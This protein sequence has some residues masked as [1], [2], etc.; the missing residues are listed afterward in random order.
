MNPKLKT[1]LLLIVILLFCAGCG[2]KDVTPDSAVQNS[3]AAVTSMENSEKSLRVEDLIS[4]TIDDPDIEFSHRLIYSGSYGSKLYLLASYQFDDG[5]QPSMWMYVFDMDTR[6]TEKNAFFMEMPEQTR[7]YIF[8]MYVTNENELTFILYGSINDKP[9]SYALCRTDLTGTFLDGDASVTEDIGY[10]ADLEETNGRLFSIPDS[11]P[12]VAEWDVDNNTA[13]ISRLDTENSD[14]TALVTLPGDMVRSLCSDGQDGF[15]Y[16]GSG[17]LKHLNLENRTSEV[18]CDLVDFGIEPY[19]GCQLL[20]NDDRKL[21]ICTVDVPSPKVYL[22]TDEEDIIDS[23]T[24]RMTRLLFSSMEYEIKLAAVWSTTSDT[25]RIKTE[26]A[27]EQDTETLRDRIMMEIASGKGPELMWVTEED[28]RILAE[29]GALMDL[30]EMIPEDVKEQLLP[31]VLKAG[32]LD[33]KLVGIAPEVSFYSM[34]VP[35]TYWSGDSWTA[36]DVMDLVE[37][38]DD[39]EWPL[40]VTYSETTAEMLFYDILGR[41]LRNSPYVDLENGISYFNGEEFIRT[42]E[43]CQEYGLPGNSTITWNEVEQM[44]YDEKT[45]ARTLYCY[46][47]LI[48][49]SDTMAKSGSTHIV[50]F[51][52]NNGS[53]SYVFGEGYLVVNANAVHI[54]EIKDYIRTLLDYENQYAVSMSPVRKDVLRDSVT[55]DFFGA[56]C[57]LK[58]YGERHIAMLTAKP[59]GSTYLEEFMEFA[60][61]CEPLPYCPEAIKNILREELAPCFNEGKSAEAAAEIIHRRVQLYFDESR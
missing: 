26:T 40:L 43:F 58:K 46:N 60:E 19:A 52:R 53:G 18:L 50:G 21:A 4:L 1:T 33:G 13:R 49:F 51:P 48:N 16:I 11:S 32:T 8:S 27:S 36:A 7:L 47:G 57:V 3:A 55:Q 29:K 10:F 37:S 35:D 2:K 22:L 24:I 28:M 12:I 59:D 30:S 42:I 5:S 25:C 39:W 56:P 23:D 38:R 61:S 54:E 41:D 17:Q 6:K 14:C 31:G 15:Y 44:M 34:L 20:I 45:A 9:T